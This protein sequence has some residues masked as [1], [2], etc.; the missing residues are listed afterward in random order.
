MAAM[1][2]NDSEWSRQSRKLKG[3]TTVIFDRRLPKADEAVW[4]RIGQGAEENGVND[5]ENRGI[6]ANAESEGEYRDGREAG[7]AL[8]HA[9]REATIASTFV[10]PANDVDVASV[11]LEECGVAEA[12]LGV[13]TRILGGH[14]GGEVVRGAHFK[15]RAQLF[16]EILIQAFSSEHG[17]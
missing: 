13:V 5:G 9:E 6:R 2:S 12:F 15:M 10:Q 11:F 4:L 8:Q 14:A 7:A 3:F 16:V 1:D 17:S